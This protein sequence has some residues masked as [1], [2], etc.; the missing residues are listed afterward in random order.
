MVIKKQGN[1]LAQAKANVDKAK[2]ALI[3]AKRKALM[4]TVATTRSDMVKTRT[5][6]K[7]L[8]KELCRQIRVKAEAWGKRTRHSCVDILLWWRCLVWGA[9]VTEI[10]KLC[11]LVEF[12]FVN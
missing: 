2:Q 11:I 8:K 1:E 12:F 4:A 5:A 7:K 3:R 10:V 6:Q 9:L